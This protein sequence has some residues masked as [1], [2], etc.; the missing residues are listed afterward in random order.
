MLKTCRVCSLKL[1]TSVQNIALLT[2][3]AMYL[4][5][6]STRQL[7]QLSRF[8]RKH[9]AINWSI[10]NNEESGLS[11]MCFRSSRDSDNKSEIYPVI[12]YDVIKE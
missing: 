5:G 12:M 4:P 9:V 7:F 1:I 8:E 2:V 3:D 10:A 11:K 6:F